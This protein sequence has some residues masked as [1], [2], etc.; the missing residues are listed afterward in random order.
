MKTGIAHD[1][2][3]SIAIEEMRRVARIEGVEALLIVARQ[4]HAC[5][6]QRRFV[7]LENVEECGFHT[8]EA[9]GFFIGMEMDELVIADHLHAIQSSY[10]QRTCRSHDNELREK[11]WAFEKPAIDHNAPGLSCA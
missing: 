10:A 4:H 5:D 1:D 9:L 11:L 7:Y 2:D 6:S 3:V 8:M